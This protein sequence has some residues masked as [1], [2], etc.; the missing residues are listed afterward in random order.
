MVF[1]FVNLNKFLLA[2]TIKGYI[3]LII[4]DINIFTDTSFST[5]QNRLG[6]NGS[7]RDSS[8]KP[9]ES[10]LEHGKESVLIVLKRCTEKL[11]QAV[12]FCVFF[13]VVSNVV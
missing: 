11:H 3:M 7:G 2:L 8:I 6:A 4:C 9:C 5:F 10:L 13:N 12:L 1:T